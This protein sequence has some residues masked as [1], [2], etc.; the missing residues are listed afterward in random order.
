VILTA[1]IQATAANLITVANIKPDLLLIVVVFVA[2]RK[3]CFKAAAV[4]ATAGFLKDALST[5]AFL[6]TLVLPI[7]GILTSLFAERFY[8]KNIFMDPLIVF[9]GSIFVSVVYLAWFSHWDYPPGIF[10]LAVRIGI[11]AALYTALA[12]LPLFF[13]LKK[14]LHDAA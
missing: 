8:K 6:N 12:G 14:I 3:G 7:Y 13:I 5:G 2:L 9:A 10:L 11:P 4:A 1:L